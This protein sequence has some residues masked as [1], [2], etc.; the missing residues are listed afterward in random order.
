MSLRM[1]RVALV[2]ALLLSLLVVPAVPSDAAVVTTVHYVPTKLPDG[3]QEL[4]RVEVQRNTDQGERQGVHATMSPYNL[5]PTGTGVGSSGLP[6]VAS[7]QIDVLGTRGSTG[8]WD[9]GGFNE[10]KAGVDAVRFLA[11]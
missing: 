7:A 10:T 11:G 8:C 6:G 1:P 3:T 9:Y 2:A 4:I 5:T